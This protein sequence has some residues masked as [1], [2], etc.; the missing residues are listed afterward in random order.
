M[1]TATLQRPFPNA[2]TDWAMTVGGI[3]VVA[4][5]YA[6]LGWH[7]RHDVDSFLTWSHAVLY[8]GLAYLFVTIAIVS[9][10]NTRR[11]FPLLRSLPEGYEL[12]LPAVA[13]FFVGGAAD[14][15]GH[16]LWGFEEGFN[17]LL[18]PTHQLIG[19]SILLLLVGPIRSALIARPRPSTLLA[20]LPPIVSVTSILAL[21]HWGINPFFE[22]YAQAAY[23]PL[24]AHGFTPDAITLQA[25]KFDLEGGGI[26]SV[27]LQTFLTAGIALYLARA[28][29][30]RPG[31]LTLALT[32]GNGFVAIALGA[33]W[34][35]AMVAI[36]AS[37]IAGIVGDAFL[38]DGAALRASRPR[39]LAFAA[40]VPFSYHAALFAFTAIAL[41]G[42]W[43]DP[44]FL[45]GALLYSAMFGLLFGLVVTAVP[46]ETG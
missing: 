22:T 33:S 11:G 18:S 46:A 30:A 41:G 3:W 4:G 13:L 40:L 6:D 5:I 14:F 16:A 27:L 32:V 34:S 21:I 7:V 36:A 35:Q 15:V 20:Q 9:I 31:A 26:A 28:L 37:I 12:A 39:M 29:A 24:V 23:A 2:A 17:A 19:A 42:V 10:A 8:A 44:I 45:F 25:M 1:S 38:R 43:W